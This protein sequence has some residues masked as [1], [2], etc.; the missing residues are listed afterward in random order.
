MKELQQ[1]K[2]GDKVMIRKRVVLGMRIQEFFWVPCEVDRVT[3]TLIIVGKR[4][5][6]K[7]NGT[8]PGNYGK[9]ICPLGSVENQTEL[10]NQAKKKKFLSS[11]ISYIISELD[12]VYVSDMMKL[13]VEE[14]EKIENMLS[15]LKNTFSKK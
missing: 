1:I 3:K 13:D 7:E 11:S 10:Y 8:E 12:R 5:F 15:I 4:R 2:A 14:L 9:G 6:R